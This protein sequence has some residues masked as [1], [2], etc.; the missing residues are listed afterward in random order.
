MA[1]PHTAGPPAGTEPSPAAA[2]LRGGASPGGALRR[3]LADRTFQTLLLGGVI[4]SVLAGLRGAERVGLHREEYDWIRARWHGCADV[5]LVGDSRVMCGLA[6]AEMAPRLGGRRV[7]NLGLPAGRL[8]EP[9]LDAARAVLDPASARPAVVLGVTPSSLCSGTDA[10]VEA[11]LEQRRRIG[12]QTPLARGLARLS[13]PLDPISP[14]HMARLVFRVRSDKS[15]YTK[16]HAD[17]WLASTATPLRPR[18][19][20]KNYARLMADS[21]VRPELVAGLLARTRAWTAAGIGVYGLRVPT[22]EAM[23]RLE[24]DLSGFDEAR[25]VRDF[26]AAGGVWIPT[27]QADYATYDGSHL[28]WQDAARFSRDLAGRIATA[29]PTP[30]GAGG[31]RAA[32]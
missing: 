13:W 20:L 23:I 32:P 18:R 8:N 15:T 24:N 17:G 26:Q 21:K 11:F 12:E 16:L 29:Q 25:F 19:E 1:R 31:A 10:G 14:P 6:P 4:V 28:C 27:G 30:G 3:A 5:V 7:L 22:T 2:R 9:V